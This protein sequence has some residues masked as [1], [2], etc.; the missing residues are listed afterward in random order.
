MFGT[1]DNNAKQHFLFI[2]LLIRIKKFKLI[3]KSSPLVIHLF[4]E[5]LLTIHK[6]PDMNNINTFPKM[7]WFNMLYLQEE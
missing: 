3:E 2:E 4:V 1:T 6:Q 7:L 5:K